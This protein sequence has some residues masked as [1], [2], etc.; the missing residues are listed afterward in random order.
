MKKKEGALD[1]GEENKKGRTWASKYAG[2][3]AFSGQNVTMV[4]ISSAADC[5]RLGLRPGPKIDL[6]KLGFK[7]GLP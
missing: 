3:E 2:Q 4:A 6:K 1:T 7:A 5:K